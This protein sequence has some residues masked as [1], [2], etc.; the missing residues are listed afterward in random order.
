MRGRHGD[1]RVDPLDFKPR[2]Y[3]SRHRIAPFL[4][5]RGTRRILRPPGHAIIEFFDGALAGGMDVPASSGY[6]RAGNVRVL[7][8]LRLSGEGIAKRPHAARQGT[9]AGQA[10]APFRSEPIPDE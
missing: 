9:R 4:R 6:G 8:L 10:I 2:L 7:T 1:L 3:G 5:V